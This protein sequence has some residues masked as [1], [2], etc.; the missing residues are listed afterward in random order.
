M[1]N[2]GTKNGADAGSL[3]DYRI[4]AI[5]KAIEDYHHHLHQPI[6]ARTAVAQ[7]F[8]IDYT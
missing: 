3:Q 4:G 6:D 1:S 2:C 8:L 5:K 7:A